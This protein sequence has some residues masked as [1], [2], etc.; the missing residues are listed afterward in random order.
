MKTALIIGWILFQAIG[1]GIVI[2]AFVKCVKEAKNEDR[3]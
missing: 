1:C 2:W 3:G